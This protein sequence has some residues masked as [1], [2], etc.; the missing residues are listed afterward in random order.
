MKSAME[1]VFLAGLKREEDRPVQVSVI[2]LEPEMFPHREL[3]GEPVLVR[4]DRR[5]PFTVDSL[6][7]L[8][9]AFD[10]VTTALAVCACDVDTQALSVWGAVFT[11]RRGRTRFD[12]EPFSLTPPDALV[13][14]TLSTGSL[15]VFRGGNV[16]ARFNSGRFNEPTPTP[17]TASLM[18]WSLL[19]GIK[20]HAEFQTNGTRYWRCYRDFIDR[21]LVE[22]NKRGHGGAIV[23]LPEHLLEDGQDWI[24]P[25]YT[26]QQG[27]EGAPLLQEL[28]RLEIAREE[29]EDAFRQGVKGPDVLVVERAIQ[30]VK[31]RIVEHVE[32]LAQMTRVDGALILSSRLRALSFGS[33][34]EAPTWLGETIYGP[35][36]DAYPAYQVDLH[37]YG[38]RHNSAVNFIGKNHDAVAFVLSQDGPIAGITGKDGDTLYWWPDCLSSLGSV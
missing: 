24:N 29:G 11:S 37:Q 6:V 33:I 4:M 30:E 1:T 15:T 21:L 17:F 14:S 22:A 18:G 8:A 10:P 36:D 27:A 16:I 26:L 23:W 20:S 13:I 35:D 12:P 5:L 9:P 38:T 19:Q 25:R 3:S 34:L 2:L 7:K 28:C 31:R 32:L